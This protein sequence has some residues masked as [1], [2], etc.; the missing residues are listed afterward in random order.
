M[1]KN[2]PDSAMLKTLLKLLNQPLVEFMVQSL[3]IVSL[4]EKAGIVPRSLPSSLL[5]HWPK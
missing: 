2:P 5:R 3:R 4:L 1:L